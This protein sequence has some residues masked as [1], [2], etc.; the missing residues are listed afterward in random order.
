M[1]EIALVKR[2]AKYVGEA[3]LFPVDQVADEELKRLVADEI[4]WA[5]ITTPKSIKMLRYLWAIAQKLADGGLYEDKDVAME[6][7]K[8]RARFARFATERNRVVI[9]PRSLSKQRRDVLGRLCDRFVFIVCNDLLP[10]MKESEFRR[11]IE[12]MVT[13]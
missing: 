5:E 1:L 8:I 3:G 6:D 9:V 2:K 11:E 12:E 10:Q 4:A 7:L 13:S